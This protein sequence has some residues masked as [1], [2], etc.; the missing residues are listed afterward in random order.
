MV[1][2][3]WLTDT[4][5]AHNQPEAKGGERKG[6]VGLNAAWR[7][8]MVVIALPVGWLAEE[9]DAWRVCAN[10]EKASSQNI[11]VLQYP[12]MVRYGGAF[13]FIAGSQIPALSIPPSEEQ[14]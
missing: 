14:R 7:R 8:L 13:G 4:V 1:R 9:A 12:R 2:Q 11:E 5:I 3:G 6:C 10:H